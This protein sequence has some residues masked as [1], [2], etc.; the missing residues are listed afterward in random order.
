MNSDILLVPIVSS[1]IAGAVC[2]VLP[3]SRRFMPGAV[4]SSVVTGIIFLLSVYIWTAARGAP[5]LFHREW[6]GIG[7]IDFRLVAKSLNAFVLLFASG[8]AFLLTLFS[9]TYM[10]G[11]PR[12]NEYY[13]YLLFTVGAA[14]GA[15]LADN[16]IVLIFFWEILGLTL[17]GLVGIYGSSSLPAARKSFLMVAAADFFLLL[18][19]GLL[20][21]L[22]GSFN[23][24]EIWATPLSSPVSIAAF[25]FVACGALTKAG[26]YPFH[27]WIPAASLA[28]PLSVMAFLPGSLDKLVG[29]Y[30]LARLCLDLFTLHSSM[31]V[32]VLLMLAGSV[33]I[34]LGVTM[35]VLQKDLR[36]MLAYLAISSSGYMVL[37]LGTGTSMGAV[38]G[39][40]HM[41]NGALYMALL[42]SVAASVEYRT[43]KTSLEELGGL[44]YMMPM[45]FA[46]FL[47]GGMALSGV[48]PFNGFFSK[49]MIYQGVI[50]VGSEVKISPLFLV[51]AL[52]GSVLTL[53][54]FLKMGHSIFL[55]NRPRTIGA[56]REV[57]FW[58]GFPKVVFA[59]A[60]IVFGI[61][62]FSIPL[63]QFVIPSVRRPVYPAGLWTP[64]IATVLLFIGLAIGALVYL[65]GKVR[66]KVSGRFIGGEVLQEEE[67]RIPGTDFYRTSVRSIDML[68]KTYEVGEQGAFDIF[69]QGMAVFRGLGAFLLNIIDRP[70]DRFYDVFAKFALLLGRGLSALHTGS[71][72]VYLSWILGLGGALILI[73][74]LL[75]G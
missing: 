27:T 75:F 2:L 31:G 56:I 34:V 40:F 12:L 11:K 32:A 28:S 24:S 66:P 42:F 59:L 33:T 4:I 46:V 45:T 39:L 73:F 43:G 53:A 38:G 7:D 64:G 52:F 35:A 49:W 30:L 5:V 68:D 6:L 25:L 13:A 16:L 37:G 22:Y 44:S 61:F 29:I 71:L 50:S 3:R 63:R 48:P 8:F 36:R 18:G 1:L 57:G 19:V 72:R 23:M 21:T 41:L 10:V 70:L 65:F 74:V 47:V 54:C 17:Y 58:M 51:A 14:C 62:A 55:G 26:V 69:I 20:Y 9:A 60:C 15:I 67:V